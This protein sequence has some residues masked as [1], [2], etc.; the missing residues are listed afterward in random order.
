MACSIGHKVLA[1]TSVGGKPREEALECDAIGRQGFAGAG[2]L[3]Q[4]NEL[5]HVIGVLDEL[6]APLKGTANLFP[7]M[8]RQCGAQVCMPRVPGLHLHARIF[9]GQDAHRQINH[10]EAR[11]GSFHGISEFS[12]GLTCPWLVCACIQSP[13][14]RDQGAQSLQ[15]HF[16]Q[17]SV[18]TH[19]GW[20]TEPLGPSR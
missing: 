19:R 18:R 10:R 1:K 13:H 12:C 7:S 11:V 2:R 20:S 4:P 6:K 3:M 14:G 16:L 8:C 17:S 9:G 5:G 15:L